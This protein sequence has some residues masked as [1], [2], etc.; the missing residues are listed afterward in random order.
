[1]TGHATGAALYASIPSGFL[2]ANLLLL[3]EFPD[4]EADRDGKRK[5]LPVQMGKRGAA[6]VYSALTVATYGWIVA[7]VVID[8]LPAWTLLGCLTAPLAVKAIA[9]SFAPDNMEK[10]MPALGANVMVVLL[11]QLLM[12]VGFIVAYAVV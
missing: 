1:L 12:G 2:V 7:G 11:T 8:L 5:T 3:N 9:G 10:L 4:M 6:I